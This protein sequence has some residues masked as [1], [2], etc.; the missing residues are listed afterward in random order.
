MESVGAMKRCKITF[1]MN[2]YNSEAY[3]E[4]T[5]KSILH[6]TERDIRLIVC[7]N[8]ST[9]R[10]G[11]ICKQWAKKDSRFQFFTNKQ[12]YV[13]D[14][15][16]NPSQR[17]Y[18]PEFNSEY[19]SMM[20]ADDLLDKNFAKEMYQAAKKY[21]A[22]IVVCGTTIFEDKTDRILSQRIPP[23]I[24]TKDMRQIGKCFSALYNSLRPIWGKVFRLDFFEQYYAFAWVAPEPL[25]N[26]WDTWTSLG[27]FM[28]C[29]AFVA[30]DKTLHFY[31]VRQGSSFCAGILQRGRIQDGAILYKRGM[32]C[33]QEL[34][35][36]NKDNCKVIGEIY[37][38]HLTDLF[39]LLEQSSDMSGQE[40]LDYLTD[41]L[42]APLT[43]QLFLTE[44]NF[45]L[46][47][48]R[49]KK[50]LTVIEKQNEAPYIIARCHYLQRLATVEKG[51]DSQ[52][53]DCILFII[54]LSVLADKANSA[55]I[56]KY[57]L[58]RKAWGYL[59]EYAKCF[60]R[61]P[62]SRQQILLENVEEL[63]SYFRSLSQE[64]KINENEQALL[65]AMDEQN[66]EKAV[67]LTNQLTLLDPLNKTA[68]YFRAYLAGIC[69]EWAEALLF[70][71][72]AKIFWPDDEDI[73]VLYEDIYQ[74]A[75]GE[76]KCRQ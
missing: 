45:P 26:G 3:L 23:P 70:V 73:S 52:Q 16:A 50:V 44:Y 63:K 48:E 36:A 37:W 76:N 22:E 19:V 55:H 67:M 58:R 65:L 21:D 64:E 59:P 5:I 30:L 53:P 28:K 12:N 18:W 40:K 7:N 66:Y 49:V 46:M 43:Q 41:M 4:Q 8:G 54:Y 69:K 11:E 39:S 27:Y 31:R 20:D 32:Q 25:C 1:F 51:K 35:I 6:Q 33:L 2:A 57:W 71:T 13:T 38:T 75:E 62:I 14:A 9:D 68:W 17:E 72:I 74:A 61:L 15:G 34:D 29:R 56:G 10:T 42:S 24:Q 47:F 60:L